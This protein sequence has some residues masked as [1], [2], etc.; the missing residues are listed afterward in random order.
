[1][2]TYFE[3]ILSTTNTFLLV[4]EREIFQMT[5][6]KPLNM[7]VFLKLSKITF[8]EFTTDNIQE[9]GKKKKNVEK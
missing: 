1:M 6:N 2:D 7:P 5:T 8:K 9:M 3:I 4:N